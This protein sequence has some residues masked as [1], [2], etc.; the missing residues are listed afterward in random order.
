MPLRTWYTL[1]NNPS[2]KGWEDQP[3]TKAAGALHAGESRGYA[4]VTLTTQTNGSE[5]VTV[6]PGPQ[7]DYEDYAQGT[8]VTV[9]AVPDEGQSFTA[10][11]DV[12]VGGRKYCQMDLRQ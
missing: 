5:S 8:K 6:E 10:W 9:K 2:S 11:R 1:V 12:A 7:G 4:G 3:A